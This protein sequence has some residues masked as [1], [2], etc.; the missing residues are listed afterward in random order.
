MPR[1]DC[2]SG[3][4][5]SRRELHR[6]PRDEPR[7]GRARARRVRV[8]DLELLER[9]DRP[10]QD[11]QR[12]HGLEER[13]R[14]PPDLRL[15]RRA[16]HPRRAIQL[17]RDRLEPA[18][19]KSIVRPLQRQTLTSNADHSARPGSPSQ[20]RGSALNQP[21]A[22][23]TTPNRDCRSS[24]RSPRSR[25]T[26][27]R[28]ARRTPP[29]NVPEAELAAERDR[30]R[31]PDDDHH[32][33][34]YEG[35]AAPCSAPRPRR[36]RR[37]VR[38]RESSG[39]RCRASPRRVRPGRRRS[40]GTSRRRGRQRMPGRAR[41]RGRHNDPE[42]R[43]PEARAPHPGRSGERIGPAPS[44]LTEY[45]RPLSPR[46]FSSAASSGDLGS[47]KLR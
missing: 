44:A 43:G 7:A 26:R 35:P 40:G 10:E 37:P 23:F 1:R 8:D 47:D 19:K 31:E 46:D 2:T 16:V 39:S 36:T 11:E 27:G 12:R 33:D 18:R 15:L 41:V 30:E 3:R 9:A 32:R 20:T 17:G 29:V 13:Q 22:V 5:T 38:A 45:V 6:Q 42:Q 34:G 24:P 4:S 14:D 28:P 21:S 25:P